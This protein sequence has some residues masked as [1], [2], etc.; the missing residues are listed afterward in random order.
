[1][2][3]SGFI[4]LKTI[5]IYTKT[6]VM[7]SAMSDEKNRSYHKRHSAVFCRQCIACYG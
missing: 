5:P 1:M 6:I 4:Q 3:Q 7:L 2:E